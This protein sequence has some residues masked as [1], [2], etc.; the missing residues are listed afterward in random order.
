MV[1]QQF[2]LKLVTYSK[3][4]KAIKKPLD[5][6]RFFNF[7]YKTIGIIYHIQFH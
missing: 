2:I 5:N 4:V 7:S 3:L 6:Q 1:T